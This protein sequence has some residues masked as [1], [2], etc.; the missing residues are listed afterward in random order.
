MPYHTL[1][2][3]E[4][5]EV[6]LPRVGPHQQ[7]RHHRQVREEPRVRERQAVRGGRR[8]D[9]QGGTEK[10]S[11]LRDWKMYSGLSVSIGGV[12]RGVK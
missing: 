2:R 3:Y 10:I 9:D 12:W 7:Q 8:R 4:S 6:H 5:Q 11:R 1:S